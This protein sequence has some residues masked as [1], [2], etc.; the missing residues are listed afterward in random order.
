MGNY[1]QVAED[2]SKTHGYS[3]EFLK[4]ILKDNKGSDGFIIAMVLGYGLYI[5]LDLITTNTY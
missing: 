1:F 4:T 3:L 2:F 5:L